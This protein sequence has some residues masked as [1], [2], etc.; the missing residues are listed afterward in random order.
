MTRRWFGLCVLLIVTAAA[1]PLAQDGPTAPSAAAVSAPTPLSASEKKDI[2]L[3]TL[4][5]QLASALRR[6]SDL[7]IDVGACQAVAGPAQFEQNRQALT[8]EQR[9]LK[10][11]I[12][13]LRPGFEWN[14]STGVFTAKPAPVPVKSPR[15]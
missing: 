12:E 4:R 5:A 13:L 1:M 11:A 9:R 7:Q 3:L 15:T 14:P 6:I 2:E 8:D 10:E